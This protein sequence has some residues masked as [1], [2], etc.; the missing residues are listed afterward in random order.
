MTSSR[1]STEQVSCSELFKSNTGGVEFHRRT[2]TAEGGPPCAQSE[3][4][5]I[6]LQRL[7]PH[8]LSSHTWPFWHSYKHVTLQW[9][10]IPIQNNED[11]HARFK[12]SVKLLK[13]K[14]CINEAWRPMSFQTCNTWMSTMKIDHIN[15]LHWLLFQTCKPCN[16][17]R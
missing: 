3:L 11:Y 12:Y 16:T 5:V 6:R 2:Y 10:H 15:I 13:V 4:K 1:W 14:A 17:K 7:P 9:K 8:I